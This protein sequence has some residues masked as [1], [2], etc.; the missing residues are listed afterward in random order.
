MVENV[1][2]RKNIKIAVIGVG[3]W[4]KNHA[5]VLYDLG[6]LAAICDLS[7]E[8]A[9]SIA[10]R[11]KAN[12]YSSVNDLFANEKDIDA[13]LICTPTKTHLDVAKIVIQN[14]CHV[15]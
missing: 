5:R 7:A 14:G 12:P 11:Y 15:F 9:K 2:K 3:G 4:G 13:C 8:R 6:V 1:I 10:G